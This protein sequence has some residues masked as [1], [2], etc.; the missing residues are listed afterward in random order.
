M[1]DVLIALHCL[2][3]FDLF[4]GG[5]EESRVPG[6]TAGEVVRGGWKVCDYG[7]VDE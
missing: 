4:T 3:V 2:K 1:R 5:V 7:R 6:R